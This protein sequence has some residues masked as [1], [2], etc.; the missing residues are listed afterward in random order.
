[1]ARV[2]KAG[3]VI[4]EVARYKHEVCGSIVEFERSDI[5]DS[6]REGPYVL[7]PACPYPSAIDANVLKW[8]K[9][10]PKPR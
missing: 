5:K 3:A 2:I 4:H 7:C 10:K 9:S 1:M 8:M 6:Q